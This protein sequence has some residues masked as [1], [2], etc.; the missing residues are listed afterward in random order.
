[1]KHLISSSESIHAKDAAYST[2]VTATSSAEGAST[3]DASSS[4][5]WIVASGIG[6]VLIL[7]WMTNKLYRLK[8]PVDLI[9]SPDD[10]A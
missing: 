3:L 4:M 10:I 1:M 6:F 2:E 9:D 7:A 5:G 8:P